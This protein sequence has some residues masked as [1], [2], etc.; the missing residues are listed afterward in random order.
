MSRIARVV[1]PGIPHHITQRGNSRQDVFHCDEDRR[2]YL[3]LYTEYAK[4]FSLA[5][6][7]WCLMDNHVHLVGVP[8]RQESLARTLG[9]AHADYSR[10]YNLRY[11]KSGHRWE[12]RFFSCPLE[13]QHSWAA[14]RYVERNPVEA[15]M[16]RDAADWRWSSARA[17]ATGQDPDG[18][19]TMAS[20]SSEFG[21]NQWR[22][23]LGMAPEDD[24]WA[25]QFREATSRGRPLGSTEFVERL[26]QESGRM[27]RPQKVGRPPKKLL[28]T[29]S[30]DLPLLAEIGY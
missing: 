3:K 23:E 24:V 10:Y 22:W 12:A 29:A 8:E 27:L 1:V 20:W 26:E 18:F 28:E 13:G 7:G 15:G 4:R 30:T 16:V 6:W 19:L 14:L 11:G 17:H 5:T 25:R 21:C 2:L 9:R